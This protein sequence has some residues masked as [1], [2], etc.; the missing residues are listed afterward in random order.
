MDDNNAQI[1]VDTQKEEFKPSFVEM[2]DSAQKQEEVLSFLPEQQEAVAVPAELDSFETVFKDVDQLFKSKRKWCGDSFEMKKEVRPMTTIELALS[3][4]PQDYADAYKALL[5]DGHEI[6]RLAQANRR[7][8]D[9]NL[10][11][12]KHFLAAAEVLAKAMLDSMPA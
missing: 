12:R 4:S 6:M 8:L 9:L 10:I 7:A 11:S 3:G 5:K 2:N 1:Q